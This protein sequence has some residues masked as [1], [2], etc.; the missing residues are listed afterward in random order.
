[1]NTYRVS[2]HG[3]DTGVV[4]ANSEK[5]ALA[6]ACPNRK[7]KATKDFMNCNVRVDLVDDKGKSLRKYYYVEEG[8]IKIYNITVRGQGTFQQSGAT[9]LEAFQKSYPDM[10]L[11]VMNDIFNADVCIELV[12]GKR[13]TCNYY[14]A[15]QKE[16]NLN[17]PVERPKAPNTNDLMQMMNRKIIDNKKEAVIAKE[18]EEKEYDKYY[19]AILALGPRI[20]DAIKLI[21][22][23]IAAGIIKENCE[24]YSVGGN[25]YERGEFG[26]DVVKRSLG[27][28]HFIYL[29]REFEYLGFLNNGAYG[30]LDFY[31]NGKEVFMANGDR[32][33]LA[34][35]IISM[36]NREKDTNKCLLRDMKRFVTQFEYFDKSLRQYIQKACR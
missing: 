28:I 34:R 25:V 26:A 10:D 12:N 13:H 22:Q 7:L 9:P 2:I 36:T 24:P 19:K 23:G 27:A 14:R 1:M 16:P 3:G 31:T 8:A 4:S 20:Q 30:N 35:P 5:E 32:D 29:E 21:N 11:Q 17:K 33:D 6:K 18:L 15:I